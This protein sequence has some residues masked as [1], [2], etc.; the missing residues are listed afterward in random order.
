L[1][2]KNNSWK[3]PV[4]NMGNQVKIFVFPSHYPPSTQSWAQKDRYTD[5]QGQ[6][7]KGTGKGT[8]TDTDRD[9]DTDLDNFNGQLTKNKT[10][11]SVKF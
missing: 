1:R 7:H 11:E 3:G 10:V 6:G 5:R 2:E 8:Q 4:Q 9:T